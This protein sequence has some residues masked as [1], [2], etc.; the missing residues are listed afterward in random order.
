[1]KKSGFKL[2]LAKLKKRLLGL[3]NMNMDAFK[4]ELLDYVRKSLAT[5]VKLTPAR[6][7]ALIEQNQ[8][9]EYQKRVNM[10]PSS[11]EVTDPC[12]RVNNSGVH[13]LYCGGRWY[14]A[15][16]WRLPANA[17]DAYQRL[18]QER[19]RRMQTQERKFIQERAQSRFLYK[20]SWTQIGDSLGFGVQAGGHIKS[21]Y[22]RRKPAK[23]PPRAY[24]QIRGGKQVLSVA[25]YNPLLTTPSRYIKFDASSILREAAMQHREQFNRSIKRRM[26]QLIRK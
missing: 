9:F 14:N 8:H 22:T 12:L 20:K 24:G 7:K 21:S 5:A 25:I 16:E 19:A 2:D 10:I 3:Q 15:S 18:L 26:L 6:D 23:E 17:Q 13:W 1:M 4:R 11:H